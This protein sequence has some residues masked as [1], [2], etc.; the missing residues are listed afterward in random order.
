MKFQVNLLILIIGQDLFC[1]IKCKSQSTLLILFAVPLSIIGQEDYLVYHDYINRGDE[2]I[3]EED[4]SSALILYDSAFSQFEYVFVKDFVMAAQLAAIL[5]ERARCME[6][7][8]QAMNGGYKLYCIEE[9]YYIRQLLTDLDWDQL[10]E[11]ES[12][13]RKKYMSSV[14]WDLNIKWTKR[15]R[16]MNDARPWEDKEVCENYKYLFSRKETEPFPSAR[17]IGIDDENM[18]RTY[19]TSNI[20]SMLHDCAANNEKVISTLYAVEDPFRDFG[21]E[22]FLNA[23]RSGDLHPNEMFR[24]LNYK[25]NDLDCHL[26]TNSSEDVQ[27]IVLCC[28]PDHPEYDLER[29]NADRKKIGLCSLETER[30]KFQFSYKSG[31]R[32]WQIN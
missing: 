21:M 18:D 13:C 27:D 16:M 24:I 8:I 23:I 4:F 19:M 28:S 30:R 5:E 32:L 3:I 17:I 2:K 10:R 12:K 6:Y 1:Q 7:I 14:D 20:G 9:L 26:T 15:Y 31:N 29:I 25:S 22:Y 11:D